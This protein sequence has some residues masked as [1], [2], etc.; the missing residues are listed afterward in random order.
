[1]GHLLTFSIH[2]S[3]VDFKPQGALVGGAKIL[4]PTLDVIIVNR[5][6]RSLLRSCLE[7]LEVAHSQSDVIQAVVVVDD[8]S[9]DGSAEKLVGINLPLRIIRNEVHTGYGAS[10]NKAAALGAADYILFLNTDARVTSTSLTSAIRFLDCPENVDIA[11]VG[12][13]LLDEDGKVSRCSARFP[14]PGRLFAAML[15]LDRMFPGVFLRHQMKD[16]DHLETREVDQVM[17]AFMLMRR[18]VFHD[19]GGYDERFF[20]YM[21]DLDLSLRA[22]QRGFKSVYLAE[23]SAYHVGGGTAERFKAESLFFNLRS[24]IQYCFKH[25]GL[26]NGAWLMLSTLSLEAVARLC[27]AIGKQSRDEFICTVVAYWR[28]W[29]SLPGLFRDRRNWSSDAP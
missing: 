12:I 20:V 6:S 2:Q 14:T 5:N 9:S 25:F 4:S 21:E 16:W 17:G 13:K 24:R 23:A 8:A 22:H 19:L 26:L 10:C 29:R 15:G 27:W 1:L 11:V 28:L 7:S 18:S 3:L